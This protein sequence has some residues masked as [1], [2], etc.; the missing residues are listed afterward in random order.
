MGLFTNE[1]KITLTITSGKKF[2]N[3]GML[4]L[5]ISLVQGDDGYI[6][7]GKLPSKYEILEY[8][9]SGPEYK[10]VSTT[11][12]T[13]ETK[14]KNKGK[15]KRKGR[16]TG[17]VVGTLLA[18]GVG[19]L[20]GAALGTGKKTKGKNHSKTV[21]NAVTT[22]KEVET[23]SNATMKLRNMDTGEEFFIGFL[24]NIRT[25]IQLQNFKISTRAASTKNVS[26]QKNA[27][28][29][30]KEYKELLDMGIITEEEFES[31]KREL[32]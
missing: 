3:M 31:K 22:D 32:L 25:D 29:L 28:E 7:I 13:N 30:L 15:E 18:P 27:V 16:L 2:L 24:C 11:T 14:G 21:G 19:T 4:S 20:A 1:N 5:S 12:T 23:D 10:T 6:T 17:A 9:W 8:S 26:N